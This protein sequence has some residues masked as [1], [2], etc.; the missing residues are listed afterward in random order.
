M[1]SSDVLKGCADTV[2]AI[3]QQFYPRQAN[4]PR[5]RRHEPAI[6]SLREP[7][8]GTCRTGLDRLYLN[9]QAGSPWKSARRP[10]PSTCLR[11]TPRPKSEPRLGRDPFTVWLMSASQ[12]SS[13][14]DTRGGDLV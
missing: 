1:K 9:F 3:H 6:E 7:E 2:L 14:S 11:G 8:I 10:T 4:Q 13:S 12:G 5:G